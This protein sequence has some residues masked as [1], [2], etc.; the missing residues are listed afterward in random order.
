MLVR[1]SQRQTMR[2]AN[3]RL[4]YHDYLQLPED[5]RYEILDGE[6]Y[7]VPAP[8]IRH[9]EISI[10]LSTILFQHVRRQKIGRV[11]EAPCDVVLS[12][13]NVVQPDILFV[14]TERVDI[15]GEM[16][17]R[18]A[19]DVVIEI[20]SPATRAKDL[21]IKRKIYHGFGVKEYWIVDLDAAT[22]EVLICSESGYV[23]AGVYG[24]S[25][26]LSSPLLPELNLPLDEVFA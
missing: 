16:N 23:S 12:E 25:Q 7:V 22:A 19:P 24:K 2:R 6:L 4:T 1:S 10:R 20:L 13:E 3:V 17:I 15:I 9:Q 21:E 14:C 11:L 18:G 26:H 5:K 8:N